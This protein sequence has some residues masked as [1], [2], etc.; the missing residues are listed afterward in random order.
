MTSS[1]SLGLFYTGQGIADDHVSVVF[2]LA[3]LR[4]LQQKKPKF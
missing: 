3:Q 2:A 1:S 4:L